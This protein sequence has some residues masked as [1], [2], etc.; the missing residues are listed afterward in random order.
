VKYLYSVIRF[1]PDPAIGERVNLGILVGS[2]D[3]NEW[4]ICTVDDMS[5]AAELERSFETKVLPEVRD[6]LEHLAEELD[7][8]TPDAG[9]GFVPDEAWMRQLAYDNQNAL[10]FDPP[11][12]VLASSIDEA[13]ESLWNDLIIP[14]EN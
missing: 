2:E 8:F 13:L 14:T 10:Q 4:E 1:V 6:R 5:R 3:S 11:L 7:T 12:P 9:S